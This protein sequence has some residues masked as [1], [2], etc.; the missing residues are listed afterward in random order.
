MVKLGV[1]TSGGEGK[2]EHN[3]SVPEY[4]DKQTIFI[5]AVHQ[6]VRCCTI[7]VIK[8]NKRYVTDA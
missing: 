4:Q 2:K 8:T 5:L 7:G 3:S 6:E 1:T